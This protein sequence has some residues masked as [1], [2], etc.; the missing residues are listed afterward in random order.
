MACGAAPAVVAR[1]VR[2]SLMSAFTSV[3]P[4]VRHVLTHG[5]WF[6]PS[7]IV[8]FFGLEM[9]GR[10][11]MSDVHDTVGALVLLLILAGIAIRHRANPIG[12][13]KRLGGLVWGI[14]RAGDR[15]KVDVVPDLLVTPPILRLR[16][17]AVY[18]AGLVLAMWAILAGVVWYFSPGGWRPF[19]VPVTYTGYLVL[20]SL[21]WGLLFVASLGGV[22]F[23]IM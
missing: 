4:Q 13:V 16:P 21:L 22:Y 7:V 19:V 3:L 2:P 6:T 20:M 8:L 10:Q 11:A 9:F 1:S 17:F 23:P 18:L 5:R 14:A 12:W 15:L